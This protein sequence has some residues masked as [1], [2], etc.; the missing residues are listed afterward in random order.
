MDD[1]KRTRMILFL[2]QADLWS[3]CCARGTEGIPEVVFS[4]VEGI[5]LSNEVWDTDVFSMCILRVQNTSSFQES[6]CGFHLFGAELI[7]H[8]R[9]RSLLPTFDVKSAVSVSPWSVLN[10]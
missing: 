4:R 8:R 1:W 10:H 6:H 9:T 5:T 7:K 2:L 3:W